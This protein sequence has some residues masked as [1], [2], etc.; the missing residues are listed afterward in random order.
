MK[1]RTPRSLVFYPTFGGAHQYRALM[2]LIGLL[3]PILCFALY[4]RYRFLIIFGN[5]QLMVA[6]R[7]MRLFRIRAS[8]FLLLPY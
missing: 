5:T 1:K 7:A 3:I 2:L 8:S 6:F 4:F